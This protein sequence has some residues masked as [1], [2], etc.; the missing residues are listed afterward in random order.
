MAAH[1]P[2]PW[3]VAGNCVRTRY[4]MGDPDNN[5]TMVADVG[6]FP[7]EREAN[8]RLIAAAPELLAAL[9]QTT[10]LLATANKSTDRPSS[11]VW[12][13]VGQARAALSK[14]TGEAG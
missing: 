10:D 12:E 9:R 11:Y 3:E 5:G 1:T 6:V 14:A 4:R 7:P 2:G 8:A 13:I